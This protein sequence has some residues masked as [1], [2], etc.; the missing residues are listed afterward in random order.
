M[1]YRVFLLVI[2][3]LGIGMPQAEAGRAL[4]GAELKRLGGTYKAVW[5]GHKA[6]VRLNRDGTL[7]ARSGTKVDVGRWQVRGNKLCIS[8]RVWTRGK[9]KCGTVER[10]GAWYVGLR[11]SNGRPRLKFRR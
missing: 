6:R 9:Y 10:Q 11:R 4:S 1:M 8:F 3:L 7:I 2:I 5:K